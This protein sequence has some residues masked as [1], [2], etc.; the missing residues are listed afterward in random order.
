MLNVT[1]ETI[2]SLIMKL[3]IQI[4]RVHPALPNTH[5]PPNTHTTTPL[6]RPCPQRTHPTQHRRRNRIRRRRRRRIRQKE[7]IPDHNCALVGDNMDAR[8]D[9]PPAIEHLA[10]KQQAHV[11]QAAV[12]PAERRGRVGQAG[13]GLFGHVDALAV[14]G[15]GALKGGAGEDLCGVALV[16]CIEGWC[17]NTYSGL[18]RG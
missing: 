12:A 18:G 4:N 9:S 11:G 10:A 13:G 14:R 6:H 15:A 5:S 7:D 16:Q 2:Y 17:G 3:A 8:A 1:S